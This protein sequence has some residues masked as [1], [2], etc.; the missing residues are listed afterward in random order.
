MGSRRS[1]PLQK[2]L[3]LA[4]HAIRGCP[5]A[6]RVELQRDDAPVSI[7]QVMPRTINTP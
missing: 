7:T 6:L 3:P 5:E 2:R 4:Q 1:I